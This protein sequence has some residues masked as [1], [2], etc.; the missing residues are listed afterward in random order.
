MK[1]VKKPVEV[2]TLHVEYDGDRLVFDED[3]PEWWEEAEQDGTVFYEPARGAYMIRTL[4]GDHK[5]FDGDYVIRGV[6][7]ELYPCKEEIFQETYEEV[8]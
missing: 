5:V 1:V 3:L 8:R 7:G 4:E 2:E 6:H